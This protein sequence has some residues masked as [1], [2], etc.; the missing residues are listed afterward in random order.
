MTL[1]GG[2]G[3]P[4]CLCLVGGQAKVGRPFVPDD[5]APVDIRRDDPRVAPDDVD[6]VEPGVEA[7]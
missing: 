1:A 7:Q 2:I 3:E 6:P 4:D 5:A